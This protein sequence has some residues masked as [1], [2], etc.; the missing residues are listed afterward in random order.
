MNTTTSTAPTV[1]ALV[2]AVCGCC[3]RHDDKPLAD[4]IVRC[5]VC[6]EPCSCV[7]CVAEADTEEPT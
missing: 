5:K 4:V 1:P 7:G 3:L 6:G 2:F